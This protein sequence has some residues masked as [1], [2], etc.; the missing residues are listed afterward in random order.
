MSGGSQKERYRMVHSP[1][2]LMAA[3]NFA[4]ATIGLILAILKLQ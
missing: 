3:L 2:L 1:E 4:K